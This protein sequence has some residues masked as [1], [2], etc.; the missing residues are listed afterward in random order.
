MKRKS[1]TTSTCTALSYRQEDTF[2][3]QK[4]LKER[5][6]E[7]LRARGVCQSLIVADDMLYKHLY[8][9]LQRHPRAAAKLEGL[10]DVQLEADRSSKSG[11]A[12]KLVRER[13]VEQVPVREIEAISM[14]SCYTCKET[15]ALGNAMRSAIAPQT[16]LFKQQ[17]VNL[18]CA[19]DE[20]HLSTAFE[21]DHI[22]F[23][24]DLK[25]A[26][27]A[28]RQ[29]L[30]VPV[31]FGQSLGDDGLMPG[32]DIFLPQDALF[33]DAWI[34]YHARNATLRILCV[35][36]NRPRKPVKTKRAK[37]L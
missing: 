26:F 34:D 19:L 29:D 8:R 3:T 21:V 32:S 13:L 23:F 18:V 27:L 4:A 10:I 36:C 22:V 11:V 37:Q 35:N 25:K 17:Q 7:A 16:R 12:V 31:E 5:T 2:R 6:T 14:K 28:S 20:S 15:P 9:V 33:R 1:A 24:A 30:V